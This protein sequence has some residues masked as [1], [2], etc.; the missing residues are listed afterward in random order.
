VKIGVVIM[1]GGAGS[2]IGGDK[3]GRLL[4]GRPL[5]SYVVDQARR[6]SDEV[7]LAVK[8]AEQ[9][10]GHGLPVLTDGP[11]PGP[12]AAIASAFRFAASRGLTAVLTLPCDTPFLPADLAE[13]LAAT[14]AAAAVPASGGRLHP[15]CALWRADSAVLWRYIEAGN[16]SLVGLARTLGMAEV[17]WGTDPFDPFFNVN[18]PADLA[19]AEQ[20]LAANGRGAV[21]P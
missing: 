10:P 13:R 4:A 2:R 19:T 8:S 17:V 7:A 1:A 9:A 12:M 6:Y 14:G 3:A 5:L 15:S 16:S 18:E 11:E 21:R 20:W